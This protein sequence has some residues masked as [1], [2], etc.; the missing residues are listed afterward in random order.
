MAVELA[1]AEAAA[2][3]RTYVSRAKRHDEGGAM[4]LQAVP[5][6]AGG[7]LAAWTCVL[8]G[9]GLTRSGLVLGLLALFVAIWWALRAV[10]RRWVAAGRR[11]EAGEPPSPG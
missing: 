11:D 8:P 3:L 7:V 2:D 9:A 4:R 1:D 6:S 5:T 10:L